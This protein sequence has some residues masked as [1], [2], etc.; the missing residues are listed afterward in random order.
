MLHTSMLAKKTIHSTAPVLLLKS[1]LSGVQTSRFYHKTTA[2]EELKD[3]HTSIRKSPYG[4]FYHNNLTIQ[5]TTNPLAK[6]A[7]E[8]LVFGKQFT[9]HMLEVDWNSVNGWTN[10]KIV[11]YHDLVLPP[12]C[13]SLHYAIQCFEGLKAYK[14]DDNVYVFRPEMNANRMNRSCAR[15]G[16]PVSRR[17][18][19]LQSH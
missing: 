3:D 6:P 13:S 18:T 5:K 15:L 19:T 8:G 2:A 12:S 9:D 10:P 16:L 14:N 11:P 4:N 1:C 7:W 17:N